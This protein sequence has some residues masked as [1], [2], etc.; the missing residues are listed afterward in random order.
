MY[1]SSR[2]SQSAMEFLISYGWVLL[3]ILL[4]LAALAYYG[5][6]TPNKYLPDKYQLEGVLNPTAII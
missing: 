6:L 2:R 3:V 4:V 1:I 5:V